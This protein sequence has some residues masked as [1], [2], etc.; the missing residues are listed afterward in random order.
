MGGFFPGDIFLGGIFPGGFFLGGFFL[1][2]H[3][4]GVAFFWV[5]FFRVAFFWLA[6][7]LIPFFLYEQKVK[8]KIWT[9]WEIPSW[10]RKELLRW[11][12][13]SRAFI[14][15]NKRNFLKRWEPYFKSEINVFSTEYEYFFHV[16]FQL[17]CNIYR[18]LVFFINSFQ[19][20]LNGLI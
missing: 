13:F 14:E 11:H 4:S 7:F 9:P 2:W 19:N 12:S 16:L 18:N 5:A 3:F 8:T 20:Y 15:A 6:F 1:G 17:F 10:E